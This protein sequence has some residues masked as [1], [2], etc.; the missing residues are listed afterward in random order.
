MSTGD[1]LL[2]ARDEDIRTIPINGLDIVAIKSGWLT[3]ACIRSFIHRNYNPTPHSTVKLVDPTWFT[4]WIAQGYPKDIQPPFLT[5]GPN[6]APLR[7]LVIPFS[8]GGNR[9]SAI[10]VDFE[11]CGGIHFTSIPDTVVR[12]QLQKH[13]RIFYFT[14]KE[15]FAK[16]RATHIFEF[17]TDT[18]CAKPGDD[19][20]CGIYTVAAVIDLLACACPRQVPLTDEQIRIFR[21][22]GVKWLNEAPKTFG[23]LIPNS[24]LVGILPGW[25]WECANNV[26]WPS[27]PKK[28]PM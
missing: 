8:E 4:S 19:S 25:F 28:E 23:F 12:T 5:P 2:K 17:V 16:K 24:C 6:N 18:T 26:W 22:N 27:L 20:N 1:T 11:H 13:L 3:E 15:F 9:W 14:F 10:Y 7:G 21:E